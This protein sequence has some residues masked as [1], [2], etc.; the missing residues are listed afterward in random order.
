MSNEIVF[1]IETQNTYQE[2]GARDNNLLKVSVVGAYCYGTDSYESFTEDELPKLWSCFER[3][4]R[5]IGYNTHGFDLPVLSKY[6]PG[7]VRKF[8][9]LDLMAEIEKH[10][11]FRVKLDDVA[12]ATLGVGKSGNG[13]QA[14]EYFRTGDMQKL[15]DYCLQ[16]VKITR[17]LYEFGRDHGKLFYVDR[18]GRRLE[19]PVDFQIKSEARRAMN[20]T[21]G[22]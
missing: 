13:L 22:L 7:D 11:G 8:P 15:K 5:L 19:I 6:Y 14:V 10:L 1:D 9:S 12:Q 2:V 4:D 3:A 17:L 18:V 21:I 20:L 16:D